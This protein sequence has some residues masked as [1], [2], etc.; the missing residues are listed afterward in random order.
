MLRYVA[1]GPRWELLNPSKNDDIILSIKHFGAVGD[2][3]VDDTAAINSAISYVAANR[4]GKLLVPRG[5]YKI[6][7]RINLCNGL[8]LIGEASFSGS[9]GSPPVQFIC[10]SVTT[11]ECLLGNDVSNVTIEDIYISGPSS[12]SQ[13]N[14]I[15]SFTGSCR[16]INLR[17]LVVNSVTTGNGISINSAITFM[18]EN[19]VAVNSGTGFYIGASCTSGVLSANYA[20]TCTVIGYYILGTYISLNGNA[21]DGNLY[22]YEISGKSIGLHACGAESSIRSAFFLNGCEGVVIDGFRSYA[23]NQANDTFIGSFVNI[24]NNP[25]NVVFI[26]CIDDNPKSGTSTS[27]SSTDNNVGSELSFVS[28]DLAKGIV[29]AIKNTITVANAAQAYASFNGTTIS[30]ITPLTSH[31]VASIV[32]NGAGDYTINFTNP[33]PSAY[34]VTTVNGAPVS[35]YYVSGGAVTLNA[36]YVTVRIGYGNT[37]ADSALVNVMCI[38]G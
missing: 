28:C 38:G 16:R 21:A 13:S 18:I 22:G 15:I 37:P 10:T 11:T 5:T 26:G 4:G 23:N 3:S 9:T 17:R 8:S 7:S 19:C 34:Y 27:V 24:N 31:N 14:N 32:K 1:S 2:G 33:L 36:S 29:S 25:K 12:G 20:N 30:P 6:T 35:G